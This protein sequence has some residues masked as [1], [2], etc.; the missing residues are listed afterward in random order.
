MD[1]AHELV[2]EKEMLQLQYCGLTYNQKDRHDGERVVTRENSRPRRRVTRVT[3]G[4][5]MA[6]LASTF[7][8]ALG[9]VTVNILRRCTFINVDLRTL[10]T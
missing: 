7:G 1:A 2:F 5:R 9:L 8:A 10:E 4:G 3:D 6:R